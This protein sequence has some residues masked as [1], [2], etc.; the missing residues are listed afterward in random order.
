MG[1]G[2]KDARVQIGESSGTRFERSQVVGILNMTPDSFSDGGQLANSQAAVA[3]ALR[4]FDEGAELLDIGGE[5]TRPGYQA[6]SA[7]TEIERVLPV[8]EG[9]L[10]VRENCLISIDTTKLEVARRALQAGAC[11]VNDINGFL[12]DRN[13]AELAAEKDAG[14]ILMRNGRI[15]PGEQP[16]LDAIK[17]SW[18]K[19]V[20]I[21]KRAG[22]EE[23]K[24]VLD[25]GIGFG[26]TR[27][28]DLEILR[29]LGDLRAFGF[30]LMLGASRK[31]IA[32]VPLGLSVDARLETSL[33]TVAAG[34]QA[35]VDYFRVHDVAETVRFA[36]L[37]D[38]IFR[39]GEID[40]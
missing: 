1:P 19:S 8:I 28:E 29:G 23:S 38:L 10:E 25:P 5:S 33:A 22:L 9:V 21:A 18:E 4:L 31:R 32:S 2:L 14:V 39:G 35:G 34:I 12:L 24:I 20:A 15:D 36:S 3:K 11:I 30:P 17:S 27:N 6:V 37:A 40:E 13:L 26:T 16:I 7:E